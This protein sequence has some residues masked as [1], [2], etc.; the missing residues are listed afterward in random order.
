MKLT[1]KDKDFLE[2]LSDFMAA[3]DLVVEL[4]D[5]GYKRMV[6]RQNYGDRIERGFGMSRQGVRWRFHRLFN[7]IYTEAYSTIFAVES[8]FGTELRDMALAIARERISLREKALKMGK[9]NLYRL[10]K[11]AVTSE[12]QPYES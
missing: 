6:L 4:K 11:E 7:E 8:R 12:D 5:D 3:R 1:D 2:A 10:K 9:I